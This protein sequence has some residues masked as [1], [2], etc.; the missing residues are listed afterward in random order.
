LAVTVTRDVSFA[1]AFAVVERQSEC[2]LAC[3]RQ[4]Q[5]PLIARQPANEHTR[6][7]LG[8]VIY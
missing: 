2:G 7:M 5:R 6:R 4:E 3:G 1:G 8:A